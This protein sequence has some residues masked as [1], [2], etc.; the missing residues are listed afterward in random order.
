MHILRDIRTYTLTCIFCATLSLDPA[1]YVRTYVNLGNLTYLCFEA[2]SKIHQHGN[3]MKLHRERAN[4]IQQGTP[5]LYMTKQCTYVRLSILCFFLTYS[6]ATIVCLGVGSRTTCVRICF[7]RT[8]SDC[9]HAHHSVINI[10][11]LVYCIFVEFSVVEEAAPLKI[12]A[13]GSLVLIAIEE[14]HT[15][16]ADN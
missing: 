4:R 8:K 10:A 7:T 6:N 12:K 11:D 13:L 5:Q 15:V 16:A 1:T 2:A 14:N 3:T 9:S